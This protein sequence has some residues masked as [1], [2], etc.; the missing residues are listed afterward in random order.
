VEQ[1]SAYS[2]S[3]LYKMSA[4]LLVVGR[5]GVVALLPLLVL[6][7]LPP[8]VRTQWWRAVLAGVV[9]TTFVAI[10]AGVGVALLLRCDRCGRRPTLIWTPRRLQS[11]PQSG[12]R[13]VTI[14]ILPSYDRESSSAHTAASI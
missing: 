6:L 10:W 1:V 2:Q 3:G 12:P 11:R 8:D 5:F 4:C 13:Y 14:F 9:G 7:S